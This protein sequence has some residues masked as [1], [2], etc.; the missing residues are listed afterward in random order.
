MH[1]RWLRPP[2]KAACR[3]TGRFARRPPSLLGLATARTSL[4][5]RATNESS[6][7]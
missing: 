6:Y 3:S 7:L 5:L 1:A 4:L 2:E